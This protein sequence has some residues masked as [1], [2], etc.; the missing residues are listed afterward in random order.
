MRYRRIFALSNAQDQSKVKLDM[1][2]VDAIC[3]VHVNGR[4]AGVCLVPPYELDISKFVHV[5]VNKLEILVYGTLA[6]HY[7]TNTDACPLSSAHTCRADWTGS[8]CY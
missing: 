2:T 6:N 7:Q 4:K 5:G 3:E 8:A 1:G